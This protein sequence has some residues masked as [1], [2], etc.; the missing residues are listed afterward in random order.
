MIDKTK[1]DLCREEID[2]IDVELCRLF[3]HRQNVALDVA[4]YKIENN[5][6]IFQGNREEQVLQKVSNILPES[7]KSA[8]NV[9]FQTIMEVSKFE[10][11]KFMAYDVAEFTTGPMSPLVIACQ[12]GEGA[13]SSIVAEKAFA[14]EK[15]DFYADFEDVFKAV[16]N[17]DAN[18]GILPYENSTAGSVVPVYDLMQHYKFYIHQCIKLSAQHCLLGVKGA[19]IRDI[20]TVYSHPQALS[21]CSIFLKVNHINAMEYSNTALAAQFISKKDDKSVGAIASSNCAEKYNLSILQNGIQN[22][23]E[24]NHHQYHD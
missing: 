14:G 5:L 8:G 20:K 4:K 19:E 6:P 24:N 9:L 22:N 10:Q 11:S 16:D 18:Y 17:G 2:A 1:L 21:Q 7:L 15:I 12:G 13:Y 23:N 3:A